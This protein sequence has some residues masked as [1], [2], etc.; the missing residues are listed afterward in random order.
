MQKIGADPGSNHCQAYDHSDH[1]QN[2]FDG[3]T[4]AS[5]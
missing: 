2:N 4:T 5:L 1:D 3:A